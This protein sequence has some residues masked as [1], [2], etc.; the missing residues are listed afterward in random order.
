MASVFS[1]ALC[2]SPVAIDNPTGSRRRFCI[3]EHKQRFY[4]LFSKKGLPTRLRVL[5]HI[6]TGAI[7]D[8][9]ATVGS[10]MWGY[11]IVRVGEGMYEL[12]DI[13]REILERFEDVG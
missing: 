11:V 4:N 6:Q 8:Y 7:I 10:L 5:R 12:T 3:T 1:C 9:G 2:G 13:G